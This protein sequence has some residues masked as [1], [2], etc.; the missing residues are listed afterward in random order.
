MKLGFVHAAAASVHVYV[1]VSVCVCVCES[2]RDGE[3]ILVCLIALAGDLSLI[4]VS[5]HFSNWL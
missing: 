4:D 2:E 5:S 1:Y 3:W